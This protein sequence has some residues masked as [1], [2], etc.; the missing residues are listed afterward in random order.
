M[1]VGLEPICLSYFSEKDPYPVDA[2][3]TCNHALSVCQQEKKCISLYD[4]FK[5]HCKVRDSKCR[6][7]DRCVTWTNPIPHVIISSTDITGTYAKKPGPTWGEPQCSAASVPTT[8]WRNDVIASS[9]P[10]IIIPVSVSRGFLV[11]AILSFLDSRIPVV[12][13]LEASKRRGQWS[14]VQHGSVANQ[15]GFRIQKRTYICVCFC[16]RMSAYY[17]FHEQE[18]FSILSAESS[19]RYD[20]FIC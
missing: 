16:M 3:P 13:T 11:L 18:M 6:M 17:Y 14:R 15:T 5:L 2:L 20:M 8:T 10:S 4:D 7:D 1:S 12:S 19:S 9:T